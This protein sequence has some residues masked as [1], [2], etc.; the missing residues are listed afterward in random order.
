M[1]ILKNKLATKTLSAIA[2]ILVLTPLLLNSINVPAMFTPARDHYAALGLTEDATDSQIRAAFIQLARKWHPDRLLLLTAEEQAIQRD[3]WLEIAEAWN[4][5]KNQTEETQLEAAGIGIGAGVGTGTRSAGA[6]GAG[7]GTS[8]YGAGASSS[9][10]GGAG[11]GIS[12]ASSVKTSVSKSEI[13][14]LLKMAKQAMA[15]SANGMSI[16]SQLAKTTASEIDR[17]IR[18][19]H[20]AEAK[21]SLTEL[22]DI[23]RNANAISGNTGTASD[24]KIF[25]E[26]RELSRL[27]TAKIARLKASSGS[28]G[29]GDR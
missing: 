5:L 4:F 3:K 23:V 10:G 29:A 27:A 28:T 12:S 15:T 2:Y 20:L 22:N 16:L 19:G 6:S 26:L 14:R 18:L 21:A 1:K 8:S 25:S 7:G 11:G 17:A 9:G 13:E 24:A